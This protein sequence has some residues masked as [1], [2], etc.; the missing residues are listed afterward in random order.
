MFI[1]WYFSIL[2]ANEILYQHT[3]NICMFCI[4]LLLQ[5]SVRVHKSTPLS[6]VHKST[7]L[8]RVHTLYIATYVHMYIATKDQKNFV[9]IRINIQDALL[10]NVS[11]KKKYFNATFYIY[12][13][14]FHNKVTIQNFKPGTL[15]PLLVHT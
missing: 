12:G 7:P 2:C 13:Y 15:W 10:H 4:I 9:L 6:R 11:F 14:K 1:A 8:S 3:I 5:N